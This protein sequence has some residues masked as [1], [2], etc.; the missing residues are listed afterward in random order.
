VATTVEIVFVGLVTFLNVNNNPGNDLPNPSAIVHNSHRHTHTRFIGWD[1][2][3]VT[4]NTPGTRLESSAYYIIELADEGEH[5]QVQGLPGGALAVDATFR[6]H[7]AAFHEYSRLTGRRWDDKIVP[8]R[9][10]LP[11]EEEV[12][13]FI[14]FDGGTL[15]AGRLTDVRYRFLLVP[16]EVG[17]L[18]RSR[19]T[20]GKCFAR[21]GMYDFEATTNGL[22]INAVSLDD[23]TPTTRMLK[24]DPVTPGKPVKI[25]IGSAVKPLEEMEGIGPG[26]PGVGFHFLEYY[27][28]E[29]RPD[30]FLTNAIPVP[31]SYD[32]DGVPIE[33][34]AI[35]VL[36]KPLPKKK[37]LEVV[38][39]F[40]HE[41][42]LHYIRRGD[43]EVGYCGP[44]QGG[45]NPCP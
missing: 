16:R 45:C 35:R 15:K 13:A 44:S 8:R 14:S 4:A 18:P 3:T 5:L 39:T 19:A 23:D 17:L 6:D 37:A 1:S 41:G 25:W 9:S 42:H 43:L 33:R 12:A 24:F 27:E 10:E 2:R 30:N 36:E 40:A 32:C 21:D 38:A 28:T 22:Q 7:I 20:D 26:R 34:A 29:T 31:I 11:K